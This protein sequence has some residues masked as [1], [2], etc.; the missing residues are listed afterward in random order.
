MGTFSCET[1]FKNYRISVKVIFYR[2]GE[3]NFL[4]ISRFLS[5]SGTTSILATGDIVTVAQLIY[6][7]IIVP[8]IPDESYINK[9]LFFNVFRI[10]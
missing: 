7:L 8:F 4:R 9:F 3:E 10:R 1:M 6:H 5:D 2:H